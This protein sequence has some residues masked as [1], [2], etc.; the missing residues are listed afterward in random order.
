MS[1]FSVTQTGLR[2]AVVGAGISGLASAWLLARDHAVTLFE[3]G[4]YLG[5]HSNTVDVSLDGHLCP[6]DTGF[7]VFNERTY[8]NLVAMFEALGV[9]SHAS[10]MSFAVSLDEGRLEWAGTNLRTVFA[11]RRNAVSPTFLGMLRDIMRF[12]GAAQRHLAFAERSGCSVGDLLT[13]GQYGQPFRQNYLLPMAS[14]IWSCAT[15]D[16]L[17]FP[18]ATFLRFCL[19]HALLQIRNRP[20]WRTVAGGAREYVSRIAAHLDDIRLGVAVRAVRRDETGVTVMTDEGSARFDAIV[21]ASHAPDTLR[22]LADA[23]PD[24]R[25]VLGSV[26]YAPNVA[27]LHTDATLLPRRSRVWSAWNYLGRRHDHANRAVCVSY[28]LN[29]LQPLPFRSPVVVTLNAYRD[30]APGTELRRFHYSHPLF[31]LAAIAAQR[32]LPAL[33][34]KRRTWYAGAWTGYGFHEDGLKSALTVARDFG[35]LPTWSKL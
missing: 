2:I 25:A 20:Q 17:R 3:A 30:P 4:S 34:G 21:F 24:E 12:N 33:Q 9:R 29:Q 31:D 16:V 15:T 26:R 14:A 11:Q 35:A 6:V 5:G 18:A 1:A 27:I 23:T 19:N 13:D 7:L 32:Q 28:L 10:D 8:P 22:M